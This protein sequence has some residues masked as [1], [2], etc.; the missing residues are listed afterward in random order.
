MY[1]LKPVPFFEIDIY[2]TAEAV[3]FQRVAYAGSPQSK[4]KNNR[5][6][7]DSAEVRVAQDDRFLER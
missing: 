4:C 1:G 2:G 7:F 3:P 6:S 5:R